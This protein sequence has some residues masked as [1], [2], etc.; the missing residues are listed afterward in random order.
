MGRAGTLVEVVG[1]QRKG[2]R[3]K[4]RESSVRTR[5]M[6][7][8]VSCPRPPISVRQGKSTRLTDMTPNKG[9]VSAN[10]PVSKQNDQTGTF[11]ISPDALEW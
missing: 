10:Q 3:A 6:S 4:D 11:C 7:W 9:I 8:G 5:L 2:R 1:I